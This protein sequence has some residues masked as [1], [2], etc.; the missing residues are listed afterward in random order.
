MDQIPKKRSNL[1]HFL[2]K[3]VSLDNWRLMNPTVPLD[4]GDFFF[5]KDMAI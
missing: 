1:Q 5:A 3:E 2:G 4:L